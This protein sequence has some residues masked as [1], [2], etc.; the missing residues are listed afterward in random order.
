MSKRDELSETLCF[1]VMKSSDPKT[2]WERDFPFRM[3]RECAALGRRSEDFLQK[4]ITIDSEWLRQEAQELFGIDVPGP[5]P[6]ERAP[7]APATDGIPG[8]KLNLTS[9]NPFKEFT[10][11][12]GAAMGAAY[13]LLGPSAVAIGLGLAVGAGLRLL[14]KGKT[15]EQRVTVADNIYPAVENILDSYRGLTAGR[16]R[17][18][19]AAHSES[20]KRTFQ[21]W[22]SAQICAL[23]NAG[24]HDAVD[25]Q[26]LIDSAVALR[27][28]I[29]GIHEG[30]AGWTS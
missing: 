4:A 20:V 26:R 3:R 29:A 2:W 19:Y 24:G 6:D 16:L 14:L 1:E 28:E 5:K 12:G 9:L 18:L 21:H 11:M 10:L 17:K 13:L 8:R 15:E 7:G 30:G 23:E 27:D 22:Q 25:W